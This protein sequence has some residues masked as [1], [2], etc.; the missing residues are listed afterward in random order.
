MF[1]YIN[2]YRKT[3]I[4]CNKLILECVLG[5]R[6]DNYAPNLF[7]VFSF[8]QAMDCASCQQMINPT[9]TTHM[10]KIK[11]TWFCKI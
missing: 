5:N 10:Y 1:M 3:F 4:V 9:G 11:Y 6:C 2:Q 7:F 8:L